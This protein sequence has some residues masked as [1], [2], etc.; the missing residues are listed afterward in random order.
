MQNVAYMLGRI[1]VK[2]TRWDMPGRLKIFLSGS[3]LKQ[4]LLC[5]PFIDSLDV[6]DTCK[7]LITNF[8]KHFCLQ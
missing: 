3:I 5:D 7:R 8:N 6:D 2:C 4:I 1:E